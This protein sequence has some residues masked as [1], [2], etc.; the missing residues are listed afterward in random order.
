LRVDSRDA[1]DKPVLKGIEAR[2]KPYN[3]IYFLLFIRKR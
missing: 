1:D 3:T 2:I